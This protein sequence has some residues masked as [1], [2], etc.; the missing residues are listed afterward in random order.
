MIDWLGYAENYSRHA[1]HIPLRNYQIEPARAIADS[2][3]QHR[4]LTFAVMMSRQA[5]KNELSAHIEAY[6]LEIFRNR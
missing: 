4:G 3:I 6:L 1:I 2:V 5:G